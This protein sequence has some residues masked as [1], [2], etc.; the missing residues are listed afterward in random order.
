M[1]RRFTLP[2]HSKPSLRRR[3]F[4]SPRVVSTNWAPV[5]RQSAQAPAVSWSA[6][7]FSSL[8]IV[9][10]VCRTARRISSDRESPVA[11]A[12]RSS[13]AYSSSL[14][15]TWIRRTT[16]PPSVWCRQSASGEPRTPVRPFRLS[17]TGECIH[18]PPGG[19]LA[20]GLLAASVGISSGEGPALMT[21]A[22][23][24][25]A[26]Y[27]VAIGIVVAVSFILTPVYNDGTT[28]YPVWRI[29]NWFMV[30]AALAILVIGFRRRRDPER[31]DVTAVEYL[32]GSF[33]YY[34]AIVL[35]MLM[36]WEWYWTLNPSSESG[37]RGDGAPDLLSAGQRTVRGLGAGLAGAIC[38]TRLAAHL[39]RSRQRLRAGRWVTV[40]RP[41]C[42]RP[43]CHVRRFVSRCPDRRFAPRAGGGA[44]PAAGCDRRHAGRCAGADQRRGSGGS[45]GGLP[46]RDLFARALS[47]AHV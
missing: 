12:T 11:W 42:A 22:K 20:D 45:A 14:R 41:E 36:L 3:S 32:R 34:G 24:L 25:V 8:D 10:Y 35:V 21:V 19:D 46:G 27:L 33:A 28:D 7:S 9:P 23:R 31:A 17:R 29:L 38:G 47:P 5:S 4:R 6:C 43:L 15:L 2:R 18:C 37:E 13:S 16:P 40:R 44:P 26:F 39:A 30:A 1:G